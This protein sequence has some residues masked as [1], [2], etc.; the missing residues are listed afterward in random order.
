MK[1]YEQHPRARAL[2]I[3]STWS[4]GYQDA[5]ALE[6]LGIE[7]ALSRPIRCTKSRQ[8]VDWDRSPPTS[9]SYPSEGWS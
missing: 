3:P 1:S 9:I 6:V 8:R 4:L 2:D 7:V 5:T